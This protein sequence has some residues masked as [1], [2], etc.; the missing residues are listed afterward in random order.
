[1]VIHT[2][3]LSFQRQTQG[4]FEKTFSKRKENNKGTPQGCHLIV[5]GREPFQSLIYSLKDVYLFPC[6]DF[7]LSFIQHYYYTMAYILSD[8]WLATFL[9]GELLLT[10]WELFPKNCL[11]LRFWTIRWRF[12]ASESKQLSSDQKVGLSICGLKQEAVS[13]S[14]PKT[15]ASSDLKG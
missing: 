12:F 4:G 7:S 3:N 5:G 9:Q 13:T 2:C 6:P 8:W 1:M 11:E 15:M 10:F 14:T